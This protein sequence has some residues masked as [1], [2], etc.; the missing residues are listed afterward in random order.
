MSALL[1]STITGDVEKY[2]NSRLE[3][4]V[5]THTMRFLVVTKTFIIDRPGKEYYL[6]HYKTELW[7]YDV[8]K[9]LYLKTV[10]CER[11]TKANISKAVDIEDIYVLG[12][13]TPEWRNYYKVV[14]PDLIDSIRNLRDLK[15][16]SVRILRS[17]IGEYVGVAGKDVSLYSMHNYNINDDRYIGI[18]FTTARNVDRTYCLLVKE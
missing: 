8:V 11:A 18:N 9:R 2:I 12:K 3:G 6:T 10:L 15:H 17:T 5:V 7:E 16:E 1:E 13:L 4:E 14:N